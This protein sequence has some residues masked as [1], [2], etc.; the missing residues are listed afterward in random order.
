MILRQKENSEMS[1]KLTKYFQINNKEKFMI[2][3]CR[4]KKSLFQVK[5]LRIQKL[6][7]WRCIIKVNLIITN[8]NLDL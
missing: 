7:F 3:V 4:L 5:L 8:K 2:Y 1:L 6:C